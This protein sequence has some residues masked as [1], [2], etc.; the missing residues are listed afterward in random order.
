VQQG[1]LRYQPGGADRQKIPIGNQLVI[2]RTADCGLIIDDPAASRHHVEIVRE[3]DSFFWK[4]LKSSN[5]TQVNGIRK[6]GGLLHP[7]DRFQIG[8][9]VVIFE[10]EDIE[11][12]GDPG[13]VRQTIL[14]PGARTALSPGEVKAVDLLRAVY[15]V[16]NE[17]ATN[18]E[19]C[20]LVDR[21]LETTIK[22]VDAERGAVLFGKGDGE[23]LFPCPVCGHIHMIQEEV[24]THAERG[25]IGISR[26]VARHVLK[27]GESVLYKDTGLPGELNASESIQKLSLRS[28]ICVPLRGKFGI[29]GVLYMDT[30][31]PER[32]FSS[33]DLLLSTAVG[34]SAGL[35]LENAN[36]HGE[37]LEKQRIDQE[38]EHAGAIQRGFLLGEWPAAQDRFRVYGETRP[39]RIVGGDF[40]DFLQLD[41]RRVGILIGDVSGKGVPAALAMAQI[42]AEFRLYARELSSPVEMLGALNEN[43]AKRSQR[44]QFCTLCWLILDL[45]TGKVVWANAGH[46]SPILIQGE[47][48]SVLPLASGP[49]VG[50]LSG[51][52]WE[53]QEAAVAGGGTILLYT[54]GVVEARSGATA[55]EPGNREQFGLQRLL[56]IVEGSSGLPPR[57]LIDRVNGE[58]LA[59]CAPAKPHDDVTMIA[60]GYGP[61]PAK[62]REAGS[63]RRKEA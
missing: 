11:P 10:V 63:E 61:E 7:G 1:F 49:P 46:H 40:Y 33:E 55:R 19:T 15:T 43:L 39:A 28:I 52:Q 27:G 17:I 54:D 23:E 45:P 58:V 38:I 26:S 14:D 34:N 48:A 16:T 22:A 53:D 62:N 57:D 4:D 13:M 47:R 21:I 42:L 36:L 3:G 31:R 29:L 30:R 56:R 6:S 24:L 9:T 59:F 18:Y 60:L 12:S 51:L 32:R 5:G 50:L 25:E 20:Q 8:N 41:S 37:I 35:A 2:G 44:G